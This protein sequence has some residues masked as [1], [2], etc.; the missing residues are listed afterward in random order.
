MMPDPLS[1]T[2]HALADPTRR[3]ILARLAEGEAT[4]NELAA[5]F[6]MSLPSVSKHLKVLERAKLISR[7]RSAQWRPCRIE[8]APLEAVDGWLGEYRTL[9]EKRFDR[10]ESYV[11]KL[12]NSRKDDE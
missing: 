2:L 10:L 7:G 12:Q 6:E 11:A 4:V 5:P 8:T 1:A 9:W 3:A